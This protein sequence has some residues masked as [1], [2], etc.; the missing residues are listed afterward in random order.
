MWD[1]GTSL[2]DREVA[3]RDFNQPG[4]EVFLFLLSIRAAGRGLNLQTADTVIIFDPDAN[5]KNEEQAVARAYR[6][7]QLKDVLVIY[8]ETVA[9]PLYYETPLDVQQLGLASILIYGFIARSRGEAVC[10]LH[11]EFSKEDDPKAEDRN[12]ERSHRRRKVLFFDF[13]G[14]RLVSLQV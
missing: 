13:L 10:G 12:G 6:I 2:E 9:D 14:G 1:E 3:I 7:G 11:R 8:L 5:P 4:S